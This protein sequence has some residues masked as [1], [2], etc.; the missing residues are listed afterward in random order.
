MPVHPDS[1]FAEDLISALAHRAGALDIAL[2]TVQVSIRGETVAHAVSDLVGLDTPQRMY[3]VAKTV[4]GL[5]IGLLADEGA[6]SLDDP[7]AGHFPELGPVHPW[8]EAT[9]IQ[10][11][12]AMRGPH[13][14]TTYERTDGSWL[15]SYFRVPPTH[16]PGTVFTYDT[17]ASYTLAA[18]VERLSGAS[19]VDYLRP[20]LFDAL[21]ISPGLRFL[22]GPEGIAH[23]GS[24]LVC[25]SRDLLRLAHLLLDD[26]VHD[27]ARLL[28]AAY[29]RGATSPQADTTLETSD[30]VLRGGY[31]YQL[32]L[33]RPGSWLLFGLGGQIVYGDPARGV[34]VTVTADAQACENGHE[35]LLDDVLERVVDPLTDRLD[36]GRADA[37]AGADRADAATEGVRSK[38]GSR[39]DRTPVAFP[40]PAPPHDR[41]HARPVEGRYANA[42]DGPGP[43]ELV[44]SLDDDGGRLRSTGSWAAAGGEGLELR[45]DRPVQTVVDGRPAVVTAGWTGVGTLDVRCALLGDELTTWRARLAWTPDGTL[46]VQSQVFGES[47]DQSWTFHAAYRPEPDD[48]NSLHATRRR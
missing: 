30:A 10:H 42:M 46:A 5:A 47:A 22:T 14:S 35:R 34:A 45:Y 39:A 19:L 6:L 36:A 33:P 17:S 3:S 24:G 13:R 27:G 1:A 29:L 16:P 44:L 32:W 8:L 23:G 40:W 38:A 21:G 7:V 18:L 9:T 41:A 48:P 43:A 31:G 37:A 20:R 25:T 12:L 15:E 11:L 28:P 4:T 2:H 26:G